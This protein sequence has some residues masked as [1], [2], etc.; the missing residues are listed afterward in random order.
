MALLPT[1]R[2]KRPPSGTAVECRIIIAKVTLINFNGIDDVFS[3]GLRFFADC[4][5]AAT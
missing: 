5:Q 4:P 2:E 1:P 3:R